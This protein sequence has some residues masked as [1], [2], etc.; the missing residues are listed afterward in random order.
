MIKTFANMELNYE[1]FG[2]GPAVVILHDFPSNRE[3][4]QAHFG[5]LS[6]VG[7]RVVVTNPGGLGRNWTGVDAEECSRRVV[8]LLNYLGVGRALVIGISAA[9]YALL[10]LMQRFPAR[11]AAASFIVGPELAADLRRRAERPDVLAALREGC[12]DDLKEAFL[13]CRPESRDRRAPLKLHRLH[14]WLGRVCRAGMRGRS[15]G[16]RDCSAMLDA[17]DPPP[18]L[19]ETG[20]DPEPVAGGR[21]R[22]RRG[23]GRRR[24]FRAL[25][26]PLTALVEALLPPE[27]C[28]EEDAEVPGEGS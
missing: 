10:D 5:L 22:K 14:A 3:M 26:A 23:A 12:C 7:C 24:P 4:R 17:F 19:V 2:R 25:N 9:G 28:F 16:R 6:E 15:E 21:S 8:A 11:V 13:A 18:L 27:E 20:A 1:D